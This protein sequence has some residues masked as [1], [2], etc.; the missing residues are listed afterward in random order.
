MKPKIL[1]TPLLAVTSVAALALALL[2][3]P[4]HATNQAP[5]AVVAWGDNDVL[6]SGQDRPTWQDFNGATQ[7]CV[8]GNCGSSNPFTKAKTVAAGEYHSLAMTTDGT[9]WAWG[10]NANGRLGIGTTG[11]NEL[12]RHVC[13]PGS[14]SGCTDLTGAKGIAAGYSHSMAILQDGSV[15]TWGWNGWGKLGT[16]D[17]VEKNRPQ[18]MCRSTRGA[19]CAGG[20]KAV[21]GG[22]AHSLALLENGTV[23]SWGSNVEGQLGIGTPGGVYRTPQRVVLPHP[24]KAKAIAAGAYHSIAILED[25]SV[26]T[27]GHNGQGQI[28]NGKMEGVNYWSPQS[29]A[30]HAK[31]KSVAA[32]VRFSMALT[33]DGAVHTW[34]QNNFGQLGIGSY[35]NTGTPTRVCSTDGCGG[36]GTMENVRTIAAGHYHALAAS[37]DGLVSSWGLNDRSQ[38]GIGSSGGTQNH[39]RVTQILGGDNLLGITSLSGGLYHSLAARGTTSVYLIQPSGDDSLALETGT[40]GTHLAKKTDSAAQ[41]WELTDL[42]GGKYRITNPETGKCLTAGAGGG[43]IFAVGVRDC[44]DSRGQVWELDPTKPGAIRST[45]PYSCLDASGGVHVSAEVIAY[46]ECH[47]QANQSWT[48]TKAGA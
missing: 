13:A 48:L 39:P 37:T 10:Y 33:E 5:D 9:V 31:A 35:Q 25:G 3:A 24:G 41:R 6:Q 7:V 38:L 30:L 16:G 46:H 1:R 15:A 8:G 19:A 28:G 17:E 20:A 12:P 29:V 47:G 18:V 22:Y 40:T 34:G 32:G 44:G 11:G 42:G 45:D 23:L 4:A 43:G 14:S 36:A 27:W 2:T 21:A 26:V